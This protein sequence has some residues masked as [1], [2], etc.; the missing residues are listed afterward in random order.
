[1]INITENRE[2]LITEMQ[3]AVL[4]GDKSITALLPFFPLAIAITCFFLP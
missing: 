2:K 4:Q 1:M 3:I